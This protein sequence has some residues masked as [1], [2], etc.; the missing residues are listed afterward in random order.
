M[1][2]MQEKTHEAYE[3]PPVGAMDE[4]AGAPAIRYP[5]PDEPIGGRL[6]TGW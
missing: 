5:D 6:S 2:P 4:R 1:S 3:Q